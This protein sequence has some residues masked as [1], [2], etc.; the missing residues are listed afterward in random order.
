M[1]LLAGDWAPGD[2]RVILSPDAPV[3]VANL[4]GP[5]L[6][7]GHTCPARPKAGPH[8]SSSVLPGGNSR[9]IFSLANNH[10][11]DYGLPGLEATRE[12]LEERRFAS[13]GA[14]RDVCEA[15]RPIIFEDGDITV[16]VIACCEAQFGVAGRDTPGVA[17]FGPWVCGAI[18]DLRAKTDAV[19]VS[20]H[21]GVEDSPWPSPSIRELYRS[22]ID[23]GAAVVHGHHPHL[24][25]GY[26]TY[27]GGLIFYGMGNFAV[28]PGMWADSPNG[29]WSL[30]AEIDFCSTPV[31]W[32]PLTFEVRHEPGSETIVIDK[33]S[34]KER[35]RHTGYL[36]KCNRPFADPELFDG[37]WQEVALRSYYHHGARYMGFPSL[38]RDVRVKAALSQLKGALLNRNP[39]RYD[40]LLR[41]HMVAC[42]SHR[43]MLTTALGVLSDEI[44]D[45][46][47]EVTRRLA[48][49]MMPWSRGVVPS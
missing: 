29:M 47:G 17:E 42:E 38:Q 46:R 20:V 49:E 35:E 15:K 45:L 36:E 13:C 19:T 21:A 12:L 27:G 26:E 2:R 43:R 9:F 30:A 1:I 40:H 33:S 34:E 8:I 3:V 31:E 11:M 41:Y 5:I 14:G 32:R 4:E 23:A 6:P 10:I 39:D 18:R 44:Q 25:Q 48:D 24:P 16:G 37:L 7:S 28:D 22:F